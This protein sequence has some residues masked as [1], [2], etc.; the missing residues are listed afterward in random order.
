[1]S[2]VDVG[3]YLSAHNAFGS[4][5]DLF[6]IGGALLEEVFDAYGL[7][8]AFVAAVF[9]LAYGF[10]FLAYGLTLGAGAGAT[11]SGVGVATGGVGET[12]GDS[13]LSNPLALSL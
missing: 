13:Q 6:S 2:A 10:A 1:M 11:T 12:T 4:P 5:A 9:A 3:A 7:S 8:V